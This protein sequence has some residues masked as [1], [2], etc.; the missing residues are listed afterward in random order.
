MNAANVIRCFRAEVRAPRH[1]L[2]FSHAGGGTGRFR[3]WGTALHG[4]ANVYVPVLAGR[5]ERIMEPASADIHAIADEIMGHLA[6]LMDCPVALAGISFGGLLAYEMAVRLQN[7]G[8]NVMALFVASQRAPRDLERVNS[9]HTLPKGTLV[10]LLQQLGGFSAKE[11]ADPEFY[12]LFLDTI[13]TDMKAGDTYRPHFQQRLNCPIF[14]WCGQ[15]D[16]LIFE[17]DLRGWSDETSAAID[18]RTF[19]TGHFLFEGQNDLWLQ[20]LSHELA[21][22]ESSKHFLNREL[23]P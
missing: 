18:R 12:D 14:A 3:P 4:I 2:C 1:L 7:H 11:A 9:W 23:T 22:L 8:A 19:A 15:L 13:R 21:V 17:A 5:D 10:R 16:P 6:P 20:A